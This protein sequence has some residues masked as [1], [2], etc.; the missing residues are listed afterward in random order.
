MINRRTLLALIGGV[1]AV[2]SI[3][4]ATGG[5]TN[6]T[7][8]QYFRGFDRPSDEIGERPSDI[9][10]VFGGI[11]D[12][13]VA[14]RTRRDIDGSERCLRLQ[15]SGGGKDGVVWTDVPAMQNV[16][17]FSVW[18]SD[19]DASASNRLK[20]LG[21]ASDSDGTGVLGGH[22]QNDRGRITE[23]APGF[24]ERDADGSTY[25]EGTEI[26]QR[27]RIS[28][29]EA[30]VRVWEWGDREPRSWT[31]GPVSVDHVTDG[32]VGLFTWGSDDADTNIFVWD[33]GVAAPWNEERWA[34]PR[35]PNL[36]F[37]SFDENLTFPVDSTNRD[38]WYPD[39]WNE[40]RD[41]GDRVHRGVDIYENWPNA[42]KGARVYAAAQGTIRDWM[43]G[44]PDSS[45]GTPITPGSGGGY[46]IHID[47]PDGHYR[48]G[49]LHLGDDEEDAHESAFAPHP[50][51]NRTLGPGD[52][53]DEGQHI[54]YL[55]DS[56]V[57]GSGPHLHFEIRDRSGQLSDDQD[58]DFSETGNV[59]GPRYD[60]YPPL[61]FAQNRDDIPT[62][63]D[64]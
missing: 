55:G 31:V 50:T 58:A 35:D 1:A 38:I 60:P 15:K 10:D 2:P 54:G 13:W 42:V 29:G 26:A 61:R 21:R 33:I 59:D 7:D 23:Y 49:Y 47:S 24:S 41:G 17:L 63:P 25:S 4:G 6:V 44:H 40:D 57:T 64:A 19:E 28:G 62:D 52:T 8:N 53:V 51:E 12:V 56:G 27:V 32:L 22:A 34:P 9:E 5:D 48:Y 11:D 3:T 36:D 45:G 39:G 37:M 30:R 14:G 18:R 46:Q 16:E 43:A 20:L